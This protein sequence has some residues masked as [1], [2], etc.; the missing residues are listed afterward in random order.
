MTRRWRIAPIAPTGLCS[1]APAQHA[2]AVTLQPDRWDNDLELAQASD[3]NADP[4]MIE[5]DID[6]RVGEVEIGGPFPYDFVV[7][8]HGDGD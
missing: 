1:T 3:G 7:N 2:Q 8:D 5:V 6:A 4:N